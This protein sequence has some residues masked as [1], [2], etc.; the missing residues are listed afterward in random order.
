VPAGF[1]REDAVCHGD[2]GRLA[3]EIKLHIDA[4]HVFYPIQLEIAS[5]RRTLSSQ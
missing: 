1:E 5:D 3:N 2:G 4:L